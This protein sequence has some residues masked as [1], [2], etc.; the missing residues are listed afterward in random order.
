MNSTGAVR[1]HVR[2]V[3]TGCIFFFFVFACY[4]YALPVG[5]YHYRDPSTPLGFLW[6]AQREL[7]LDLTKDIL[8]SRRCINAK[9]SHNIDREEVTRIEEPLVIN[10]VTIQISDDGSEPSGVSLPDCAPLRLTVP[11]PYAAKEQF[12]E[13]VFGMAT[14]YDRLNMPETMES[15]EHWA[16]GTGSK[17]FVMVEDYTKRPAETLALQ[18]VYRDRDIEANFIAP[19]S[20]ATSTSQNH[21]LVLTQMV[22][23]SG[24]EAKWFGLLDDDTFFPHL[25]P[26]STALGRLDHTVDM[27]V[28]TLSEDFGSVRN[29]GIMAYG[30]AGAYL[31]VHLA[32]KIGAVEQAVACLDEAPE[33]L[34]DIVLRNCVYHHSRAKLTPLHGL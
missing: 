30:G 29:F 8:Y 20:D 28:G 21:F 22:K 27:Y 3:L 24:P 4:R 18:A 16:A 25:E 7:S 19:L 12:P 14:T 10:P 33:N 34:G 31:S 13:L 23:E 32:K 1:R 6:R 5:R 9:V 2:S 11:N 15:I 26:L 17:W